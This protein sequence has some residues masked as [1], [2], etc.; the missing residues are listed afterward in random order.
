MLYAS[1]R[2]IPSPHLLNQYTYFSQIAYFNQM[3]FK[4]IKFSQI[5]QQ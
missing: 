1:V 2:V 4:K 5:L 3:H